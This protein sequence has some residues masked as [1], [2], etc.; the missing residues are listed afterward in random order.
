MSIRTRRLF[1]YFLCALFIL[2]GGALVAYSLGIKFE[3]RTLTFSGTGGVYIK[4][5]PSDSRIYLDNKLI[6]NQS[7]IFQSGTFIDNLKEGNYLLTL[8]RDG[9]FDWQ[10]RVKIASSLVEVF[11]SIVLVPKSAPQWVAEKPTKF[12]ILN[13]K[14]VTE[15][16]GKILTNGD[17][18]PGE[19]VE[20]LVN[21]GAVVTYNE[22]NNNHYLSNI[23]TLDS[24]LNI[25]TLFYNLKESRL[26]LPGSVPIIKVAFH[27]FNYNKLIIQTRGALYNLDTVNLAIE[28]IAQEVKDFEVNGQEVVF[29]DNDAFYRYNLIFRSRSEFFTLPRVLTNTADLENKATVMDFSLGRANET[30]IL[31]NSGELYLVEN[32]GILKIADKARKFSLGNNSR[33]IAFTDSR[34]EINVYRIDKE[35]YTKLETEINEEISGFSWYKDNKHL[36][37]QTEIGLY[38]VEVDDSLPLNTVKLASIVTE[39]NYESENGLLYFSTPA[40]IFKLEI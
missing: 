9:Y 18:L 23:F 15:I 8:K 27:P 30:A 4:S 13:D 40:G 12:Y 7:G 34:G 31:L 6:E 39:Y 3:L 35:E 16:D 2:I 36:F 19:K 10:K 26:G 5:E 28:K 24:S 14:V 22:K 1:F 38:F 17:K 32:S 11:D 25:N 37:I 33:F 29:Y 21:N 20:D